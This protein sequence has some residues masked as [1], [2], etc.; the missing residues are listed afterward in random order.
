MPT[1]AERRALAF[2]AA[3]AVTGVAARVI[4]AREARPEPAVAAVR[5]LD[6]QIAR[7]D[8]ARQ[9]GKAKAPGA[10]SA[11]S[12]GAGSRA[13]GAASEPSRGRA[14]EPTGPI[15]LDVAD[16]ATIERLPWVGPSLA[17][18]IV[19]NRERCGAFG[20]LAQLTRVNGIGEATTRRLA[21]YVTF[22]GRSRP[23]NAAV[24]S[25]CEN[26]ATGAAPRRRGRS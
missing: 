21:P 6:A 18:R 12:R 5:A 26:A 23:M 4:R 10:R 13:K 14:Q 24:G 3:I 7:V 8:S 17:A 9:A 1:G 25:G 2:A 19:E 11:G 20:S 15:D 16:A 22:S